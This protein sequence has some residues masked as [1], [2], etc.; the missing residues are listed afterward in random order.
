V[1]FQKCIKRLHFA[2]G[3]CSPPHF[4][5][6]VR[7]LVNRVLQQRC[8]WRQLHTHTIRDEFDCRVVVCRVTQGTYIEGL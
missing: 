5:R 7:Q 3:R 1:R 4:H 2:T 8:K 6:N